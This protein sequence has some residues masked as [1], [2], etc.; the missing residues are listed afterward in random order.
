MDTTNALNP[1]PI[2]I[3]VYLAFVSLSRVDDVIIMSFLSPI[4]LLF[5]AIIL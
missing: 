3:G 1:L 4:T 5:K 2:P